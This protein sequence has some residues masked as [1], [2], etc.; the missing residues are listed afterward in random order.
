[1]YSLF[2]RGRTP[3]PRTEVGNDQRPANSG[4]VLLL[5]RFEDRE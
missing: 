1:M 3:D 5:H 4:G 2:N